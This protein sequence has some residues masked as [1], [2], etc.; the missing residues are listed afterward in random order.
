MAKHIFRP[1]EYISSVQEVDYERLWDLGI[2]GLLFDIDNTLATYDTP[3]PGEDIRE[4]F[5]GL[6]KM[7]FRLGIISNGRRERVTAFGE[8]LG[9]AGVW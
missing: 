7:G 4:L 9:A 6:R 3:D 1:N 5:D 8:K 2:R